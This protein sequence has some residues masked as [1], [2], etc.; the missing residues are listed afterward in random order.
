VQCDEF[1][2]R[3]VAVREFPLETGEADYHLFVDGNRFPAF[4]RQGIQASL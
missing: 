3:G 1:V 2:S 4:L